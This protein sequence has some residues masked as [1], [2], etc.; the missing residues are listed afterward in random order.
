M[1]SFLGLPCDLTALEERVEGVRLEAGFQLGRVERIW[2]GSLS[3]DAE[4][5]AGQTVVAAAVVAAAVV[6]AGSLA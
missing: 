6:V 3:V 4:G 5:C 1:A 2:G